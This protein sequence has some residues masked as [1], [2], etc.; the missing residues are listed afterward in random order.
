MPLLFTCLG[1]VACRWLFATFLEVKLQVGS[2]FIYEHDAAPAGKNNNETTTRCAELFSL[3]WI[4]LADGTWR[5][6]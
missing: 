3:A 4:F 5:F 2:K 6:N 1:G